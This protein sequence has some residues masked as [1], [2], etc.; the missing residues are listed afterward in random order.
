[1]PFKTRYYFV[2]AMDVEAGK[3]DLLND[4]YDTEHVPAL[5][6]VP[7]VVSVTRSRKIDATLRM[8]AESKALGE[9]APVFE[10]VYEIDH[11]SVLLSE[12][13]AA[14]TERGRW[15]SEVRPYTFNRRH[16]MREVISQAG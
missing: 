15:A 6:E 7:G 3:E 5:M 16:V 1:M 14:A 9:D 4:V 8:G 13:W 11:P 2:A 12:E 10:A